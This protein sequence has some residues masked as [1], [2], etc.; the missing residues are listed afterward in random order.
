MYCVFHQ[1][2]SHLPRQNLVLE[3][4]NKNLGFGQTPPPPL[5]EPNDQVFPKIILLWHPLGKSTHFYIVLVRL[6]L[7]KTLNF[8]YQPLKKSLLK[9]IET[10]VKKYHLHFKSKHPSFQYAGC[11]LKEEKFNMYLSST[12]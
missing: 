8:S 10:L 12:K 1:I 6:S 11:R 3:N 2:S 9:R 5:V 7:I 4:F